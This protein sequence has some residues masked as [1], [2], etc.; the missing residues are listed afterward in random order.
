VSSAATNRTVHLLRGEVDL[1]T[2]QG[3]SC[4]RP[5]R[6]TER[7]CALVSALSQR[8]GQLVE[9]PDLLCALGL[10]TTE[11]GTPGAPAVE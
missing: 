8:E 5:I 9:R 2:G 3:T 1:A 6:L 7:E 10:P 11:F 4:G